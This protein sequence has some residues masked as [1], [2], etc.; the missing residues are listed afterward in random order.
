[1]SEIINNFISRWRSTHTYT[2]GCANPAVQHMLQIDRSMHVSSDMTYYQCNIQSC[3]KSI[4][5]ELNRCFQSTDNSKSKSRLQLSVTEGTA[6]PRMS[7][8]LILAISTAQSDLKMDHQS[9]HVYPWFIII[10][11]EKNTHNLDRNYE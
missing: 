11:I 8:D 5:R 4:I 3:S 1:M 2:N 9:L 10:Y 7:A 6:K